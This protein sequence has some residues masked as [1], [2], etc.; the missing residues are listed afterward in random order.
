MLQWCWEQSVQ[1]R[2]WFWAENIGCLVSRNIYE[3][4]QDVIVMNQFA[5]FLHILGG[6]WW[7]TQLFL[8]KY[9]RIQA[10]P[11]KMIVQC[12][13]Y[14]ALAACA[15]NYLLAFPTKGHKGHFHTFLSF[16]PHLSLW[17]FLVQKASFSMPT[18]YLLPLFDCRNLFLAGWVLGGFWNRATV[19]ML[20]LAEIRSVCFAPPFASTVTRCKPIQD[21]SGNM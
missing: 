6:H 7:Q 12:C 5:S 8:L 20:K 14:S 11:S 1:T 10:I 16:S 13:C 2:W 3:T 4:H 9:W 15:C 17:L 21:L 19:Q 18:Q